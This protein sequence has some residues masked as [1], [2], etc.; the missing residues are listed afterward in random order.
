[1][2]TPMTDEQSVP[3]AAEMLAQPIPRELADHVAA[4]LLALQ[5]DALALIRLTVWGHSS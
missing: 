1:M 2:K 3:S 4:A 5:Q